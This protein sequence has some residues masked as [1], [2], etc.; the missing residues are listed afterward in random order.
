VV[1]GATGGGKTGGWLWLQLE[2]KEVE[3]C[4]GEG[5]LT[6]GT[7]EEIAAIL[8]AFGKSKSFWA[9]WLLLLLLLLGSR[10]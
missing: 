7:V 4:K 2:E 3:A 8:Y 9:R 10:W 5:K 1:R 6:G